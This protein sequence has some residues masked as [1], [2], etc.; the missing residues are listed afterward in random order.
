MKKYY[1]PS[2]GTLYQMSLD[3][4]AEKLIDSDGKEI[5]SD[6]M[7]LNEVAIL[8]FRSGTGTTKTTVRRIE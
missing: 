6:E 7:E 5:L 8:V 3:W 2:I 1:V 4:F